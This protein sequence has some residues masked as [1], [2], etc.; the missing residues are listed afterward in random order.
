M[1]SI[2][3][4]N[5][6]GEGVFWLPENY[7]RE[8]E[9]SEVAREDGEKYDDYM[10]RSICA[11]IKCRRLPMAHIIPIDPDR[12]TMMIE[13]IDSLNN[14]TNNIIRHVAQSHFAPLLRSRWNINDN[15]LKT[16]MADEF[17][18]VKNEEHIDGNSCFIFDESHMKIIEKTVPI[19]EAHD[20]LLYYVGDYLQDL[21]M[22][23]SFITGSAITACLIKT[24]VDRKINSWEERI[25]ILYPKILTEFQP[26]VLEILRNE[27]ITLWNIQAIS[28][29]KGVMIKGQQSHSF[30]IK[31]G[32]DVDI[33]V[34]NTV[35][36]EEYHRTAQGHYD[37]IKRY[38]PYVKLRQYTKPKG[39]CNY[40][41][42]TDDPRYIP[43][44]RTVEIYRSSFR[45]ICSHHVG[46]VR[47]C[48]TSLW[49]PE[50]T[51]MFYLT[52]SAMWTSAHN[53][54]PNYHY[55]AGRKSNPQ[56]IIVKNMQRGVYVSDDILSDIITNFINEKGITL[57]HMPFY[58]G[59]GVPSS[60]FSASYE[61]PEY[62]QL[63]RERQI[64][65]EKRR[66]KEQ[67]REAN[68]RRQQ[69]QQQANELNR[70]HRYQ[71]AVADA[72]RDPYLFEKSHR[73]QTPAPVPT[74]PTFIE[75]AR[76]PIQST[77]IEAEREAYLASVGI[78][79]IDIP[80]F[81]LDSNGVVTN[82][83]PK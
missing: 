43:V 26:K 32:S 51:P 10:R 23:R 56:D 33:A 68:R 24:S 2:R 14:Y 21:D 82:I 27:N 6:S 81:T 3:V 66:L 80:S 72:K 41:I 48:Y 25:D 74:Q 28:E 9:D 20:R 22:S 39:D 62:Q 13:L 57:S 83:I 34:D 78:P 69:Q 30:T 77:R 60:V 44:F 17:R 8:G 67:T 19:D 46:A 54:T 36:D 79:R 31:S 75:P 1:K 61:W 55:F 42:Y 63:K 11:H 47:G 45:N 16:L 52:A 76:V 29:N 15:A 64:R 71:T 73:Y 4:C 5:Y 35:S 40:V 18:C 53:S 65:D 37:V 50:N 58:Y 49:S 38:Y 70:I 7:L 12:V 59:V